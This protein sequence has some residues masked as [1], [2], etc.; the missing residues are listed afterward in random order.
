[1]STSALYEPFIERDLD[2]IPGAVRAYRDEHGS[3]QTFLAV[4]RFTVLAYA[5]SQHAKHALLCCLA[6]HDLRESAGD[7]FDDLVTECAIYAASSRQPWS[8]PPSLTPPAVGDVPAT[9]DD[10][11]TAERWLAARLNRPDLARDYFTAATHDF[12][13]LGHKLIVSSAAWRLSNILGEQG[14]FA[15]LR[16][17]VWEDVAY[18]G[19]RY[20]EQGGALDERALLE[21][22]IE[23]MTAGEG[24]L[25]SAHAVFLFDAAMEAAPEIRARV[26]DY[27][28]NITKA[29][30]RW[31]PHQAA[32]LEIPVY[33]FA[34]DY[35]ECL[36]AHAAVQRLAA[37]F[38]GAP[39]ERIIAAAHYNLEHAQ[40]FEEWSFA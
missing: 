1:V 16:L 7:R 23:A 38:P 17:G 8:E 33:R 32:S 10:R 15:A 21:R 34:R 20:E 9:F 39:V 12:E 4:A 26:R 14:R 22:L 19:N 27:L 35:G 6:V 37:R 40:S 29:P 18:G 11:I 36:K 3:E 25:V 28:T 5:P 31:A 24:D 30:P 13:D 2:A